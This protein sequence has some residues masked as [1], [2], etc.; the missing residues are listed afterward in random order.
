MPKIL[1]SK[2]FSFFYIKF[3]FV[4]DRWHNISGD[5]L[6]AFAPHTTGIGIADKKELEIIKQIFDSA[7]LLREMTDFAEVKD[8]YRNIAKV[9]L[10]YRNMTIS[11]DEVLMD[12]IKSGA[13]IV[14]RGSLIKS[15][16][17]SVYATGISGLE[18]HLLAKKYNVDSAS[19]DAAQVMYLAG[20][21]LTDE[22]NFKLITDFEN[23][24]DL[25]I[26]NP[27][28]YFLQTITIVAAF[29]S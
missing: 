12:T 29:W 18:S 4:I 5:K 13:V 1:I 26:E 14:G 20:K 7:T 16:D 10:A 19:R 3:C 11:T 23:Y 17:F 24:K 8:T 22:N 27:D 15:P 9:E 21:I 6:T 28:F 25:R 2:T